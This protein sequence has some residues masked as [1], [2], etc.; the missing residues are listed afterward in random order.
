MQRNHIQ[1]IAVAAV[2]L[3]LS[4]T[5]NVMQAQHIRTLVA[6]EPTDVLV[7][8]D[9]GL[10]EGFTLDGT[11]VTL[12]PGRDAPTVLYYFRSS[13]AWCERNWDNVE[14]LAQAAEGRYRVVAISAE[15]DLKTMAAQRGLT[16]DIIEGIS[17]ASMARYRFSGTPHT[18]VVDAAGTVAHSWRGAFGSRIQR[19]VEDVFG[20]ALPGV[21][22][23]STPADQND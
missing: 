14:A 12:E 9:S 17:T 7:G 20:V 15:R 13:C 16:V 5:V 19:Q 3:A 11:A 21:R 23:A 6:V 8:R 1:T 4:V 2:L 18:V 10:I 22:P